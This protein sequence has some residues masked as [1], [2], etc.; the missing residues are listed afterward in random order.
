MIAR[1]G[2]VAFPTETVYGLGA[3]ALDASAVARLFAAKGRPATDPLIVHLA[4]IGQ[5]GRVARDVPAGGADAGP[6]VLGRDRSRSSCRSSPGRLRRRDRRALPTVAVRVPGA[7]RRPGVDGSV[8]C[9]GRGAE[10]QSLLA[11]QPD[12]SRARRSPISMACVDLVLDGGATPIGVESTIVDCTRMPP[13]LLRPGGITHEQL[14]ARTC[15]TL[16]R[17]ATPG[18][19]GSPR[20]LR[21]GSCSGTTRRSA[22]SRCSSASRGRGSGAARRRG[23]RRWWRR[24]S[25]SEFWLPKKTCWRWRR[26]WRPQAA[27]G[28]VLFRG[29]GRRAEPESAAQALFAGLARPRCG[30]AGRHPRRRRRPRCPWRRHPRPSDA[31]GRGPGHRCRRSRA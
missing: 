13:V 22:P 14:A 8:R 15:R 21:P 6:G 16:R 9:P 7:S 17:R 26:C 28:R 11:P 5:L 3:N 20:R 31:C 12:P 27:S 19:V 23:A 30:A 25:V 10:R 29:Y 18:H 1:G 24:G 4:H 2:L